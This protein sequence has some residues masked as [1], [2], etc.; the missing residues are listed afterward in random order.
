MGEYYWMDSVK[1]IINSMTAGYYETKTP[2]DAYL[3]PEMR[4]NNMYP[5]TFEQTV[6]VTH[7]N[8][9]KRRDPARK[10]NRR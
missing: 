4:I 3:I 5:Y 6:R 9:P 8:K 1:K 2:S 10:A 7:Y